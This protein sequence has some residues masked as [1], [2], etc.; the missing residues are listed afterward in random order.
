[1][2]LLGSRWPQPRP[3][4]V[5]GAGPPLSRSPHAGEPTRGGPSHLL[6]N[7]TFIAH[8]GLARP[9]ARIHVR[10]L[11]PCFKT[12]RLDPFRQ[13]PCPPRGWPPTPLPP[14]PQARPRGGK[15]G[16]RRALAWRARRQSSAK[17]RAVLSPARTLSAPRPT[18]VLVPPAPLSSVWSRG[19]CR[20]S[21]AGRRKRAA[22]PTNR[23]CR[24]FPTL[25]PK[26]MLACRPLAVGVGGLVC[27]TRAPPLSG[28]TRAAANPPTGQRRPRL[29]PSVSL[30]TISRAF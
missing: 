23:S 19:M 29:G 18:Q 14:S 17:S 30:S 26:L 28:G 13:H 15:R 20:A 21:L 5:D 11:G 3:S 6:C 12:G 1:M 10:L 2:L 4:P 24:P 7:L 16:R 9:H 27:T 8:L 25:A 22:Q